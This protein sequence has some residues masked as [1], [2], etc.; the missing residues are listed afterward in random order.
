M[1][2][3]M[4]DKRISECPETQDPEDSADVHQ[5]RVCK[6]RN[7]HVCWHNGVQQGS[8]NDRNPNATYRSLD[9]NLFEELAEKVQQIIKIVVWTQPLYV[10]TPSIRLRCSLSSLWGPRA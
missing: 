2:S 1:S 4:V 6:R 7:G 8:N 9:N 10:L 3:M 5:D